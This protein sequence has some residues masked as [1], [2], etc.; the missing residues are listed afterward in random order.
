LIGRQLLMPV[1]H[2]VDVVL[3]PERCTL[4]ALFDLAAHDRADCAD[5]TVAAF[6]P[7][8]VAVIEQE[9]KTI[10]AIMHVV[11]IANVDAN[12]WIVGEVAL[13]YPRN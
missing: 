9:A 10:D 3:E 1:P 13:N 6:H 4:T 7:K 12:V 2:D 8:H 5:D 11:G